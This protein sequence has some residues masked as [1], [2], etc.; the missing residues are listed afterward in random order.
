M[1]P[2]SQLYETTYRA[3]AGRVWPIVVALLALYLVVRILKQGHPNEDVFWSWP[4]I[5]DLTQL[6]RMF[7]VSGNIM[8]R[9]FCLLIGF[10]WFIQQ[11]ARLGE[12][13]LAANHILL[14][15]VSF[16]AFF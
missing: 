12:V 13:T 8:I 4:R 6:T 15:F 10:G 2:L 16:S 3:I 11:G 1:N 9:T 14:Q 7:V 5:L